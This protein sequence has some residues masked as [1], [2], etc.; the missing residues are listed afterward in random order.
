MPEPVALKVSGGVGA[1]TVLVNGVPIAAPEGR[2][3]L[4]F[5]PD[6]RGFVRL[7]VMDARGAAD[8][9]LVRVQ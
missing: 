1:L 7:T 9:V 3:M 2:R 8:S 6:G 5:T 4:F